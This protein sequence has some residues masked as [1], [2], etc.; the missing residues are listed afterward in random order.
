MDPYSK[1]AFGFAKAYQMNMQA[2]DKQRVANQPSTEAFAEVVGQNNSDMN[3]G[4]IPQVP[5]PPSETLNG[6]NPETEGYDPTENGNTL[7]RAKQKASKYL[8]ERE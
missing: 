6:V 8:K 7:V 1:A 5:I 3:Y 2:A 4:P